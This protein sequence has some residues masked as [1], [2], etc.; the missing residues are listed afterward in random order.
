MKRAVA[1][2][3]VLLVMATGCMSDSPAQQASGDGQKPTPTPTLPTAEA[4]EAPGPPEPERPLPRID[5]Y[6]ALGDSFT[7]AP[8]VP[9]YE[10]RSGSCIR[11]TTN[12]P[13]LVARK[14]KTRAVDRSCSGADTRDLTVGSATRHGRVP[15]QFAALDRRTDL[16]T[17]SMGGN[18][19]QVFGTL[20]T[21]C[22]T[23][24]DSDPTGSPCRAEM[25][26]GGGDR[27]LTALRETRRSLVDAIKRIR[28]L[29][30]RARVLVV[31]YP[32]LAPDD[33]SCPDL[34]PLAD[35]DYA[36]A[37]ELNRALNEALRGA[38][39]TAGIEFVDVYAASVGHDVCSDEP[40]VN[41][42][43]T[44]TDQA[45]QYHPFAREQRAVAELVLDTLRAPPGAA[46]PSTP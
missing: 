15:P 39:R 44:I 37:D 1:A 17:L 43:V 2:L 6:V 46:I 40:W 22:P 12:Y 9:E 7:A 26:R 23:Y 33:G 45:L 31:G 30:P 36:Y 34:L 38:A 14:L 13:K 32:K 42:A 11:S 21:E 41:G 4:T 10:Q 19:A 18:D 20:V 16:V 27:L 24:R 35:G 3:V 28:Q 25:R 5:R 29:A 8:F